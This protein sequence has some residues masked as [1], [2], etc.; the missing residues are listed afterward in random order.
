M[1]YGGYKMSGFGV[2]S[3]MAAFEF[4]SQSKS[5]WVDLS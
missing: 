2:E 1:P 5:V 4:Y 3:G